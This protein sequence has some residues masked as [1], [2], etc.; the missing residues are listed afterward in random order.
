MMSKISAFVIF[1]NRLNEGFHVLALYLGP[2]HFS[3]DIQQL[4]ET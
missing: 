2:S 1:E 3:C 4:K